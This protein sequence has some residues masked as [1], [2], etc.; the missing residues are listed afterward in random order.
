MT[1]VVT[2]QIMQTMNGQRRRLANVNVEHNSMVL[3]SRQGGVPYN[4][5]ETRN[6]PRRKGFTAVRSTIT[7]EGLPT[8]AD[9][10]E[11]L[12]PGS[13]DTVP[14]PGTSRAAE[15]RRVPNIQRP[16][17]SHE[18]GT[19]SLPG[20]STAGASHRDSRRSR[21]AQGVS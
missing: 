18:L 12:R 14:Q 2:N 13:S 19:I 9:L 17:T 3:R 15:V 1:G 21:E 7:L 11:T 8:A 5:R 10:L 20:N 6:Q 16:G 4:L